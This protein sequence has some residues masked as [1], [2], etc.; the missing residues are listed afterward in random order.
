MKTPSCGSSTTSSIV[1]AADAAPL[2]P[3][4]LGIGIMST[5]NLQQA[6]VEGLS[7]E[8]GRH[9]NPGRGTSVL[10]IVKIMLHTSLSHRILIIIK[11]M[12]MGRGV[13]VSFSLYLAS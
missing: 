12:K 2:S 4:H 6:L 9:P 10:K 8:M 11:F 13:Y 1:E 5:V 3:R 7:D